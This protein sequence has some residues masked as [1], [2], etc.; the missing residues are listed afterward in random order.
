MPADRTTVQPNQIVDAALRVTAREGLEAASLRRVAEEAGT[1]KSSILHHF[2]SAA[3]LRRMMVVRIS[4]L[5]QEM[6]VKAAA[7]APG[8][9]LASKGPGIIASV[10]STEQRE[11]HLAVQELMTAASRDP[12]MAAEAKTA[13]ERAVWMITVL[14]GPPLDSALV[15]AQSI[16]AVVQGYINLWMWSGEDDPKDYREAALEAAGAI[17]SVGRPDA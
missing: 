7:T 10:F 11:F 12:V 2:G 16:V 4:Q 3:G 6:V 8:T 14:V 5:Y 1:S 13:F 15:T 9:D 17:L